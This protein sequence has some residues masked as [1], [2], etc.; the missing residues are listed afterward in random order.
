VCLLR[1]LSQ[2]DRFVMISPN[3]ARIRSGTRWLATTLQRAEWGFYRHLTRASRAPS[4]MRQEDGPS[5]AL[6]VTVLDH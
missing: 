1:A 2:Y 5:A 4:P 6:A 3:I